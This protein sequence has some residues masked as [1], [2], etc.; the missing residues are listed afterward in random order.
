MKERT[1]TA[2]QAALFMMIF[3]TIAFTAP[4]AS[5]DVSP[6]DL[7]GPANSEKAAGLLPGPVLE[8]VKKG[9]LLQVAALGFEPADFYPADALPSLTENLGKYDVNEDDLI[10]ETKTGKL[11]KFVAGIPFPK[12]DPAD[13]KAGAK[14]MYDKFYYNLCAGSGRAPYEL[15]WIPRKGGVEREISGETLFCP[16]D[17][18]AGV[19]GQPNPDGIEKF[20]VVRVLAPYDVAGTNTLLW[21]YRDNR[22]DSTFAYV[23]AIRRMRQMSPANRSDAFLGTDLCLDDAW[24]Y[25][26]KVSAFSWKLLRVQE[27]LVP[28]GDADPQ[29]LV[30]D[31]R[32]RWQ[33]ARTIKD[34][35]YGYQKQGWTGSPWFPTNIVWAKRPV[36]VLEIEA[37]D[38]YYNYGVSTLWVDAD[39]FQVA[40]KVIHDRSGKYWKVLWLAH[41]ALE[42]PDK[43]L[44]VMYPRTQIATD[45]RSDHSTC[46]ILFDSRHIWTF[47]ERY[48]LNDFSLAGF[49]R[50]CK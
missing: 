16:M 29:P 19:K 46:N 41:T 6:G 13:P 15:R 36:Y 3:F 42:S 27:A 49:Q 17:G 4:G 50:L 33:N 20:M 35:V 14:I 38:P 22:P 37:K 2:R 23:P 10:V 9:D 26:G 31:G 44:R 40:F 8:W 34:I 48:D 30:T 25:D 45:D 32:G 12:I 43:T 7:I 28:F 11:P 24:G 1:R 47:R 39:T 18:Y 21:R 5:S